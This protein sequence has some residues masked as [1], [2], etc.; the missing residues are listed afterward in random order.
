LAAGAFSVHSARAIAAAFSEICNNIWDHSETQ[1]PSLVGFEIQRG[2]AAF[3]VADLGIGI[4]GSLRTN[5]RYAALRTSAEALEKALE[6]GVSRFEEPGHGYGFGDL[7]RAVTE[8][9]GTARLRT[10]EAKLIIDARTENR[11]RRRGYAP[12]LPGLQIVLKCSASVGG[13]KNA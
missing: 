12:S 11:T 6:T 9:W 8:Q 4:L 10:G 3:C 7:L 5:P 1:V 13:S 2:H